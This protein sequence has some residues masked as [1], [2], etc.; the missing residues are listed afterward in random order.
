MRKIAGRM[1]GAGI[2]CMLALAG[3][4]A[5]AQSG[6]PDK[7]IRILVGFSAGVAPDITSRL[8]GDKRAQQTPGDRK[9]IGEGANPLGHC[10]SDDDHHHDGA[11]RRPEREQ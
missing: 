11:G 4:L 6:Y 3:G 5:M 7:P 2:A 8:F 10:Q 1:G 9:G